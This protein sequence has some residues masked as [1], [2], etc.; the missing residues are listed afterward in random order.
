MIH[1]VGWFTPVM[2]LVHVSMNQSIYSY[3]VILRWETELFGPATAIPRP[4]SSS[5]PPFP[6]PQ[7]AW[8]PACHKVRP[9]VT[10]P[11]YLQFHLSVH[12][13]DLILISCNCEYFHQ[14]ILQSWPPRYY[15]LRSLATKY[16]IPRFPPVS[17]CAIV[18]NFKVCCSLLGG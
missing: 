11:A 16:F 14:L 7:S 5:L 1:T 2:A 8:A 17:Y 9:E 10:Q 6:H 13:N 4:S 12:R 15:R 3:L 18:C